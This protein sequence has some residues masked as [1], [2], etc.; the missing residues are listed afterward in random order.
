MNKRLVFWLK[1]VLLVVVA[2]VIGWKL[3]SAWSNVGAQKIAVDWRYGVVAVAGFCASMLTSGL[4]WRGLAYKMESVH[5]PLLPLVGA[6]T[7]SQMGKYIPGKV[8]LLLM[9]IERSSRFGMDAGVCT[10]AT[11]L[12]NALYM[13]SGGL[14]GMLAIARLTA[15]LKGA[16]QALIWPATIGGVV[17]LGALCAPPVFY[18]LVNALLR[19]MKKVEVAREQ[20]L[21][22]VSLI[23]AV[24]AFFP[25]WVFGGIALWG[26][27]QAV[28]A[29]PLEESWWF[30]GAFALSVIIGMASLLPGGAVTREFLIGIAVTIALSPAVGQNRAVVLAGVVAILQRLFQIIAEILMGLTGMMLTAKRQSHPPAISSPKE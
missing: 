3:Y 28:Q 8:A 16:Q 29:L 24:V 9:R 5:P 4:V 6:Y 23:L 21:S 1:T 20:R 10:L 14:V 7:F 19:K 27:T 30:A 25:S 15:E 22:S 18:R 11:L 13:V 17:L 12:E 26:S 2:G